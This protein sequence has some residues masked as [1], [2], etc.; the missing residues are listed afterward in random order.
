M[1]LLHKYRGHKNASL[2]VSFLLAFVAGIF[3]MNMGQGVFL[4]NA[5]LLDE[6]SLYQMKYMTVNSNTF[7]IYVLKKRITTVIGIALLSSTYLGLITVYAYSVWVGV[8]FGMLISASILRYG[9]KG[10]LLII[11]SAFPQYIL[12]VP[13]LIVLLISAH[14]M[15]ASIYFPS[16][17]KEIHSGKNNVEKKRR[18]I[19]F[20]AV[21][22]VV[23]I[24]TLAESY[25]NPILVTNF[26]RIF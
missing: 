7:F 11:I 16:K 20:A 9:M 8:S 26:L 14:E 10:F 25:V 23:I 5:G 13:A 15:C 1:R 4:E 19:Q 3:I 6:N 12:Y 22:L 2:L 17:C 24:G 21:M 18:I